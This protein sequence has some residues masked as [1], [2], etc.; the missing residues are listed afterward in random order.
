MQAT[1]RPVQAA[2]SGVSTWRLL[3]AA[4]VGSVLW[5]LLTLAPW[6]LA[7]G[8]GALWLNHPWGYAAAGLAI[9]VLAWAQSPRHAVDGQWLGR[10]D[11]PALFDEIERLRQAIGAPAVDAVVL[12]ETL[13]AGAT[14]VGRIGWPGASRRVLVLGLPLLAGL[15]EAEAAAVVA[16]ELGHFSR[17]HD[18]WGQWLYRTR[19]RWLSTMGRVDRSHMLLDQFGTRF[20]NWFGPRFCALAMQHSRHCE[21]QADASAA[22]A[23]DALA[24]VAALLRLHLLEQ[25]MADW[26]ATTLP[27]LQLADAAPLPS[28]GWGAWASLARTPG[29]GEELQRAWQ[30][31]QAVDDS[32]PPLQRRAGALGIGE[33]P[34]DLPGVEASTC[35]G[36]TWFGGQAWSARLVALDAGHR[37]R[38]GPVWRGLHLHRRAW[39]QRL[40]RAEVP[41]PERARGLVAQG[42]PAQAQAL[43]EDWL[44]Q[45]AD[46][47]VVR[48]ELNLQALC[49][50]AAPAAPQP[51]ASTLESVLP[52][53]PAAALPVRRALLAHAKAQGDAD[54]ASRHRQLLDRAE[55]RRGQAWQAA[56]Q[57][58]EGGGLQAPLLPDEALQAFAAQCAADAAVQ[59]AWLGRVQSRSG[60]GRLFDTLAMVLHADADVLA[61]QQR[62]DD[63]LVEAFGA[64][65]S[66]WRE[67]PQVMLMVR[68]MYL[69]EQGLPA[70]L[71]RSAGWSWR[72]PKADSGS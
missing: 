26:Q 34:V 12:D 32:H 3:L 43:R 7:L 63:D 58:I 67:G 25:R 55:R 60:D 56:M 22:R 20:A 33:L 59:A 39:Q 37:Q 46:D 1:A 72:R 68:V 61:A 50:A 65:L 31:V 36:A 49:D 71:Q 64:S 24:L 27:R 28:G 14:T 45:G 6:L 47:A 18:R 16:H 53:C 4:T 15:S 11:A 48:I 30:S 66:L 9:V 42:Q 5:Q 44:G 23:V 57:A 52:A 70:I 29:T 38:I 8:M 40:A 2:E 19:Q 35:A 21:H 62:T 17:R 13:N 54:A 51:A 69:A 41:V 10:D